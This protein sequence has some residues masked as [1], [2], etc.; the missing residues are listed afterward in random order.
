[1]RKPV[2]FG[3]GVLKVSVEKKRGISSNDIVGFLRHTRMEVL[4]TLK[5][6]FV[7][8]FACFMLL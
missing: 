7:C 6:V 3:S 5:K 4:N 2:N 8:L 1:M